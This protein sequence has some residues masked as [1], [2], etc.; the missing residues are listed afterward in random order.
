MMIFISFK[1]IL[2][3]LEL[4][5]IEPPSQPPI[6]PKPCPSGLQNVVLDNHQESTSFLSDVS[7]EKENFQTRDPS[8]HCFAAFNRSSPVLG[9][10]PGDSASTLST[11]VPSCASATAQ[12]SPCAAKSPPSTF[13]VFPHFAFQRMDSATSEDRGHEKKSSEVS[14]E[15]ARQVT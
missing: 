5:S 7:L 2:E 4:L 12:S 13:A 10:M 9:T 15:E 1:K 6:E 11:T 3:T 14:F 8:R